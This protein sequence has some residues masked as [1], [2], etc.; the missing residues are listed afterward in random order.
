M[1]HPKTP[2]NRCRPGQDHGIQPQQ[3]GWPES[4]MDGVGDGKGRPVGP[5]LGQGSA[6]E[7]LSPRPAL[8]G[9]RGQDS[10]KVRTMLV[11]PPEGGTTKGST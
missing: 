9:H 5:Y 4:S 11:F 10:N 7:D 8:T 2:C 1:E 6:T 3:G